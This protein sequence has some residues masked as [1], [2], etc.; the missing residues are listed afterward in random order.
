MAASDSPTTVT[1]KSACLLFDFAPP[2]AFDFDQ[3]PSRN[4]AQ[5]ILY[6]HV[7]KQFIPCLIWLVLCFW[8]QNMFWKKINC[9]RFWWKTYTKRC[10]SNYLISRVKR[11]SLPCNLRL[12]RCFQFQGIIWKTEH[13]GENLDFDFVSLL[14]TLV[15]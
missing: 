1:V 10:T 7:T 3:K 4:I 8:F 5:I 2:R 6:H 9:F 14:F 12:V 15:T 11:L 13:G